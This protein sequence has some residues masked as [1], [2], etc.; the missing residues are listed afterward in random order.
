MRWGG[1]LPFLSAHAFSCLAATSLLVVVGC[2]GPVY[3]YTVAKGGAIDIKSRS[4]TEGDSLWIELQI[5]RLPVEEQWSAAFEGGE[6]KGFRSIPG[7]KSTSLKWLA[8]PEMVTFSGKNKLRLKITS[9]NRVYEL[10]VGLQ[11]NVGVVV[12]VLGEA[13]IHI[14]WNIR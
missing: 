10:Q 5:A 4:F 1:R 13:L 3:P 2:R 6:P 14:P 7:S 11:S 8:A 9:G 12:Q